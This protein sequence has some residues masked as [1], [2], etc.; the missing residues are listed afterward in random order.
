MGLPQQTEPGAQESRP[1]RTPPR[2]MGAELHPE[3]HG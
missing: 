2:I 3:R 1:H